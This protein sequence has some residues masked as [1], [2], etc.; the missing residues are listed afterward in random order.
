MGIHSHNSYI[1]YIY[2]YIMDILNAEWLIGPP[3]HGICFL[4]RWRL[5]DDYD[6]RL[7]TQRPQR[8]IASADE[9]ADFAREVREE[10]EVSWRRGRHG[11]LEG[12]YRRSRAELMPW[13]EM[14]PKSMVKLKSA[15]RVVWSK[16]QSTVGI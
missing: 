16:E 5:E 1:L 2:I 6:L 9:A 11:P 13:L 12:M 4:Q 3:W 10:L 8:S 14:D 7:L 15:A